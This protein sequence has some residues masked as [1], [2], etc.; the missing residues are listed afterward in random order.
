MLPFLAREIMIRMISDGQHTRIPEMITI[1]TFVIAVRME[2]QV[3]N[4]GYFPGNNQTGA[5]M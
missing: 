1:M 5:K 4:I 2:R 3:R